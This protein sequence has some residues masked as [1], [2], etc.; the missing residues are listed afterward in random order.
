MI[1]P[2]EKP[3]IFKRH[4]FRFL[5]LVVAFVA[6]I[7]VF[8]FRS[9]LG[10]G[11]ADYKIPVSVHARNQA[12]YQPFIAPTPFAPVQS[13]IIQEVLQDELGP[14]E[15]Q[16]VY[17]LLL[18]DM[19][20]PVSL[21]AGVIETLASTPEEEPSLLLEEDP[22]ETPLP[23]PTSDS[24]DTADKDKE[25]KED[26]DDKD[27][28]KED[29]DKDKE[30]KDKDKEDKDK[31]KDKE[32]EDDGATGGDTPTITQPQN[33]PSNSGNEGNSQGGNN[34]NGNN[35]NDDK[36]KDKDKPPKDK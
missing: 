33:P 8:L 31:D 32:D 5:L 28:D 10:V 21:A 22:F 18:E 14:S 13:N 15:G 35:G 3:S 17:E 29:K 24:E 16:E 34:N 30:D 1:D 23:E 9:D 36:D 20:Q 26:K 11:R 6:A 4:I 7:G 2:E 25:D 12:D 27:K 19:D